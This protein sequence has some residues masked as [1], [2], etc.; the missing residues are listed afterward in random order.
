M[1]IDSATAAD[2]DAVAATFAAARQA[3]MPWLPT[4]HSD[5]ENRRYFAEHVIGRCDVLVVRRER[6]PLA[7]LA[8]REDVVEHLYVRPDAQRGGIGSALLQ[9]AKRRR[10]AGLR[11]WVF[12]RNHGARAFYAGHGFAEVRLTDGAGNQEREPDVLL[13]WA[14]LPAA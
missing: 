13:A 5:A 9:A 12:Q 1:E 10:P 6:R 14:G 4:L 11:L 8:L 7:F 2:A 3:A